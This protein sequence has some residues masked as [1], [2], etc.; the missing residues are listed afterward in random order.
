[1]LWQ[2]IWQVSRDDAPVRLLWISAVLILVAGI[3]GIGWLVI[4]YNSIERNPYPQDTAECWDWCYE[5]RGWNA[6]CYSC[7]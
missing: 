2:M 7:W 4:A 6:T 5:H 1:M 3:A